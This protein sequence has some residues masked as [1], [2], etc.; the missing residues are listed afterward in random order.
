MYY[1]RER[2]KRGGK[3]IILYETQELR[4]RRIA[5]SDWLASKYLAVSSS[6]PHGTARLL[7]NRVSSNLISQYFSKLFKKIQVS[8]KSDKSRGYVM[9]FVRTSVIIYRRILPRARKFAANFY[10]RENQNKHFMFN[11]I[12]PKIVPFVR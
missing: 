3:K 10:F 11:D 6:T 8:L 4:A 12:F 1:R 7:L 9:T 2:A 5:K